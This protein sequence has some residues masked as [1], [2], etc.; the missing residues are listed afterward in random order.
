MVAKSLDVQE[1]YR[2]GVNMTLLV[3]HSPGLEHHKLRFDDLFAAGPYPDARPRHSPGE[4]FINSVCFSEEATKLCNDADDRFLDRAQK[5]KVTGILNAAGRY[6][7]LVP[8]SASMTPSVVSDVLQRRLGHEWDRLAIIANCCQYSIRL[9]SGQLIREGVPL[10]LAVLCMCLVNGEILDNGDRCPTI[11]SAKQPD[12]VKFLEQSLFNEFAPPSPRYALT[13]NKSCRFDNPVLTL[14]GV[15]THGY[16]WRL[17]RKP[18]DT[19]SPGFKRN[20]FWID[21]RDIRPRIKLDD[22]NAL[23]LLVDELE[24]RR[25]DRLAEDVETVVIVGR[26]G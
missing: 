11:A 17:I 24:R 16:L 10:N 20:R 13:F 4:L 7:H 5:A 1:N 9:D 25:Q 22:A 19:G 12:F 14:A 21:E 3:S 8:K 18:I 2:A 23:L 6:T 26:R 15:A